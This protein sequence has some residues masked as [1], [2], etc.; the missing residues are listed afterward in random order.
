[1]SAALQTILRTDVEA[2]G[3]VFETESLDIQRI[4]QGSP[5]VGLRGKFNARLGRTRLRYQVDVGLGDALFPEPVSLVPGGLLGMPAASVRAYTPYTMIAE[6][7]EAMVVLGE[8]NTRIKD[9]YD[10]AMLPRAVAFDGSTLLEAIRR[11]F[12]QRGTGIPR[13]LE[14]L[15][16]PFASSPV[17]TRRWEALLSRTQSPDVGRTLLD[18]VQSIREF[19]D[20]LLIALHLGAQ[21]EESWRDGGPWRKRR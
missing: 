16:T 6:K 8:A 1:L 4:R 10:L 7:L 19:V 12:K 15:A 3:I 14:G 9:Y 21:F 11:T 18:A 5:V 20:P 13:E 2:D 17:N